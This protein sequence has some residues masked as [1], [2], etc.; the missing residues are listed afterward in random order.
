MQA[1]AVTLYRHTGEVAVDAPDRLPPACTIPVAQG[2]ACDL[3]S[4]VPGTNASIFSPQGGVRIGMVDLAKIGR[5][6]LTAQ[7][8][9]LLN[10]ETIKRFAGSAFFGE[11]GAQ[12]LFCHYGLG[13]QAIEMWGSD[14]DD[15]LFGKGPWLGHPG[16]AYGLLSGLWFNPMTKQGFVYFTTQAPPPEGGED[17]GNFT[18][19]E[20]AL[21][22]RG[23]ALLTETDD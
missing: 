16:E 5:A 10:T 9:G 11:T 19:R 22:A 4:Y 2:Q 18:P 8:A 13:L 12:Q 14:C 20:K 17:T 23:Q 1:R 6:L 21:M 3:E 15:T 7:D